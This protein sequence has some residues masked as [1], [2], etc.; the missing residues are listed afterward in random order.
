MQQQRGL[1]AGP[2][3]QA[4]RGRH[5]GAGTFQEVEGVPTQ[6]AQDLA[7]PYSFTGEQLD[8]SRPFRP[9]SPPPRERAQLLTH[10]S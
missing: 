9:I 3:E 4:P 5:A 2:R 8:S 1:G 6:D 7:F 10:S